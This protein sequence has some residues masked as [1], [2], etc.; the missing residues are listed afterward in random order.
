M[1]EARG[2]GSQRSR[3]AGRAEPEQ[4]PFTFSPIKS[5]HLRQPIL[6]FLS[7][8]ETEIFSRLHSLILRP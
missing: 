1:S 8:S 4:G 3:G 5:E 2:E 7:V 6:L